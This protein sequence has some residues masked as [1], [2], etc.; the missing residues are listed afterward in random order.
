MKLLH[1]KNKIIML[2]LVLVFLFIIIYEKGNLQENL[3]EYKHF[4]SE[5][6]ESYNKLMI[7]GLSIAK[8]STGTEPFNAASASDLFGNDISPDDNYVR[9]LDKVRYV[10]VASISLNTQDNK[11]IDRANIKGGIIKVRATLPN[12]GE[13]PNLTW[14]ED[15]WMKNVVYNEDKT[16]ITA[17]FHT[18]SSIEDIMSLTQELSFTVLVG[19]HKVEISPAM[20]P[21]FEVWME[22]N[23]PDNHDSKVTSVKIKDK[24]D[25]FL[26]S[27]TD[28]Y[29]VVLAEDYETLKR[30]TKLI[31]GQEME[32]RYKTL[33][34]GVALRKL[35]GMPDYRGVEYPKDE[36]NIDFNLLY[37][38]NLDYD[39]FND[40]TSST[41]DAVDI[42][43]GTVIQAYG[44][45]GELNDDY[46]PNSLETAA[47]DRLPYG[48]LGLGGAPSNSVLD[49]GKM[50]A[51]LSGNRLSVHF[52]D[53][54][55]GDSFPS[56]PVNTASIEYFN[57]NNGFFLSG[58][59]EFFIPFY[60]DLSLENNYQ[61]NVTVDSATY[62][63]SD[64]TIG[65]IENELG[66]INDKDRSDNFYSIEFE[67]TLSGIYNY[68]LYTFDS[69]SKRLE[70]SGRHYGDAAVIIGDDFI[71][72]TLHGMGDGDFKGGLTT[73]LTWDA[74]M[75][76][77]RSE[78]DSWLDVDTEGDSYIPSDEN[79]SMSFGIY[80]SDK[81]N[82]LTSMS[83][84]NSATYNSFTWY[85]TYEEASLNGVVT[86]LYIDDPDMMGNKALRRYYN[87]FT[88][89]DN[90]ENIGKSSAIRVKVYSYPNAER[91]R[92]YYYR[93]G[94]YTPTI[95][96][97]YGQIT[98]FESNWGVGK[99]ILAVSNKTHVSIRA[100]ENEEIKTTYEIQDSIVNYEITPTLTST[101]EQRIIDETYV[102]AILPSGLNY[103]EES[104]NKPAQSVEK[105][106]DGTTKITWLYKNWVSNQAPPEYEK[107][108]FKAE[109]SSDT[110]NNAIY[111]TKAVIYN[112]EDLRYESVYRSSTS[113]INV[114]NLSGSQLN[115]KVDKTLVDIGENIT[116]TTTVGNSSSNV[117]RNV[118]IT[119]ILP[120]D[121]L[122]DSIIQGK[123]TI[124]ILSMD[125]NQKMYYSTEN[126]ENLNLTYENG[127]YSAQD[128]DLTSSDWIEVREGST[129]PF[130]AT[131]LLSYFDVVA[132]ST[133]SRYVYSLSTKDSKA[134]DTYF[135]NSYMGSDNTNI[136]LKNNTLSSTVGKRTIQGNVLSV[137]NISFP[138]GIKVSLLDSEKNRVATTTVRHGQYTFEGLKKGNYYV[139]FEVP[140]GYKVSN[141]LGN[142]VNEQG[143]T[144]LITEH[145]NDLVSIETKVENID[146]VLAKEAILTINHYLDGT[147]T[148][149][150][151]TEVKT[152]YFGDTYVTSPSIAL[153]EKYGLVSKTDNFAGVVNDS[154]IVVNYFY[155]EKGSLGLKLNVSGPDEIIKKNQEVNYE[156]T[157]E[158]EI[159]SYEGDAVI[160]IVSKIPYAI[161][162]E[163]SFLDDG[164]YDSENKTI[165]WIINKNN[166][167]VSEEIQTIIESRRIKLV[168]SDLVPTDKLFTNN[169]TGKIRLNEEKSTV[170][171][172]VTNIKIPGKILVHHY[173]FGTKERLADD[174]LT[175]GLIG[176]VYRSNAMKIDGYKLVVEPESKSH[177]YPDGV[178]EIVYEYEKIKSSVE[179]PETNTSIKKTNLL[180]FA[181]LG[182]VGCIIAFNIK[183]KIRKV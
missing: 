85:D 121:H 70:T 2:L 115:K 34:I 97:E 18:S 139:S 62:K 7:S 145:S 106:T 156:I 93:T 122:L 113:S 179:N 169:V 24:D 88:L 175:T 151:D 73:L 76:E 132:E 64:G 165:T 155:L 125:R 138:D 92:R 77:V 172:K 20:L 5:R 78:D 83:L 27:G 28:S 22:G 42:L 168:F 19:G 112:T 32:G 63:K 126:I 81:E 111:R 143:L 12:Q 183:T 11:R 14:D 107:I 173:L 90:E 104:A 35:D 91:T 51:A 114:I 67:N 86:A 31:N 149:L 100:L 120:K 50:T 4:N 159:F 33:P 116:V 75:F 148:K 41:Q 99:T 181:L 30:D 36:F 158:S 182:I 58:L 43:N 135:F 124:R 68:G 16:E 117:M 153:S 26:I 23:G 157:F 44:I 38:Y 164:V 163:N 39:G 160:T 52:T 9:T 178:L 89:I 29:N 136:I 54:K 176:D 108:T 46:F 95:Y 103:V 170:A 56:Y 127:K 3:L 134:L 82:G 177:F 37:Q 109:I 147:S 72:E 144:V 94:N 25:P 49:S 166:L 130:E 69:D 74:S 10:L 17:E 129:I 171:S 102:Y 119:E 167:Q 1:K 66:S 118:R 6:T 84:I 8:R 174:V 65:T 96:N 13:N 53:F 57:R 128:V 123:Y 146:M 87:Y 152:V 140:Q 101:K 110:V 59:V 105:N 80:N 45:N 55:I 40:I 79:I 133:K 71:F 154:N 131:V 21:E 150:V 162:V 15:V 98:S 61:L 180:E 47:I 137:N 48:K 142:Q 60:G 141:T 161:D